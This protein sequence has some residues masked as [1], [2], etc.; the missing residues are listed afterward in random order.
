MDDNVPQNAIFILTT[1]PNVQ[2][3]VA[4]ITIWLSNFFILYLSHIL[5]SMAR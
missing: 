4:E 3:E 5:I 2:V 1:N